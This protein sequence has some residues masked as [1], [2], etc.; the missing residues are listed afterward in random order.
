M[1]PKRYPEGGDTSNCQPFSRRHDDQP[2]QTT[3]TLYI[4]L[5]R[6]AGFGQIKHH[7]NIQ[8]NTDAKIVQGKSWN[9]DGR[10][11]TR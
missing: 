3:V 11:A 6:T 10:A 7:V 9:G 2:G 8:C 5:D 1:S 4:G